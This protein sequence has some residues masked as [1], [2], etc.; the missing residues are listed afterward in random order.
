MGQK[1]AAKNAANASYQI[2]RDNSVL[3]FAGKQLGGRHAKRLGDPVDGRDGR[4]EFASLD[5]S[6]VAPIHIG[7]IGECLLREAFLDSQ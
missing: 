2:D 6:H 3:G 1:P 4:A 5:L 7:G